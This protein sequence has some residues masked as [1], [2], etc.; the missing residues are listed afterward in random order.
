MTSH[1]LNVIV[2]LLATV[3]LPQFAGG[4]VFDS[5]FPSALA[6]GFTAG[7]VGDWGHCTW[8][9]CV[10]Y[11]HGVEISS[12]Y[13][14]HDDG[15]DTTTGGGQLQPTK[16]GMDGHSRR[17]RRRRRLLLSL[18]TVDRATLASTNASRPPVRPSARRPPD[19][20]DKQQQQIPFQTVI[21]GT[22]RPVPG[23]QLDINIA[24]SSVGNN[25]AWS[26]FCRCRRLQ[27]LL[28]YLAWASRST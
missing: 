8:G 2:A 14:G 20:P 16:T 3:C 5:F 21:R 6:Y 15:G 23:A 25:V 4:R 27:L 9:H 26:C 22:E 17:Q 10:P 18:P 24:R 7:W 13:H 28:N 12:R 1:I 11:V 19:R